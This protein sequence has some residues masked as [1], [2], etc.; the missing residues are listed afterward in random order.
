MLLIISKGFSSI[1]IDNSAQ[2]WDFLITLE[3]IVNL[4]KQ[5]NDWYCYDSF[6]T[7][8]LNDS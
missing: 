1:L 4:E 3:W 6:I 8:R 7:T 2:V 5:N